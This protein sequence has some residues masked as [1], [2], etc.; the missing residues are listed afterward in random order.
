MK[1]AQAVIDACEFDTDRTLQLQKT[2]KCIVD[3]LR[4][5]DE[6]SLYTTIKHWCAT[7]DNPNAL[8]NLDSALNNFISIMVAS[9]LNKDELAHVKV[10]IKLQFQRFVDY[11]NIS[12][13]VHNSHAERNKLDA[14]RIKWSKMDFLKDLYTRF[15]SFFEFFKMKSPRDLREMN[16]MFMTVKLLNMIYSFC[17]SVNEV[18]IAI[19]SYILNDRSDP[20]V[21]DE[22][23][24][25]KVIDNG[26]LK[27]FI[28]L[29]YKAAGDRLRAKKIVEL[30]E[31][32][33]KLPAKLETLQLGS[34]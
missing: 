16:D 19:V 30:T 31:A 24:Q 17:C 9:G 33:A 21:E 34:E 4:N 12:E 22:K 8:D 20:V 26:K 7:F 13:L 1:R 11:M 2:W 25:E 18:L 23:D 15:N 29:Q 27:D 6:A 14:V 5:I 28:I 3:G 10:E 32:E